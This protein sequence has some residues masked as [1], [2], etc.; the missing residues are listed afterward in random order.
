MGKKLLIQILIISLNTGENFFAQ[1]SGDARDATDVGLIHGS[2]RSPGGGNGNPLQYSC[3][4]TFMDSGVIKSHKDMTDRLSM[5]TRTRE[6]TR[7]YY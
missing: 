3:L 5:C 7:I 4:K 6:H 1:N 2:G